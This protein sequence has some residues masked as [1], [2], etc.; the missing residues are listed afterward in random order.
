MPF[1][2][3][4]QPRLQPRSLHLPHSSTSPDTDTAT[5]TQIPYYENQLKHGYNYL[6]PYPIW[7]FKHFLMREFSLC[8]MGRNLE[9]EV[10]AT[11]AY[12]RTCQVNPGYGP[13]LRTG[14]AGTYAGYFR[15]FHLSTYTLHLTPS[16]W[17]RINYRGLI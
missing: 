16:G 1:T 3:Y 17:R 4:S 7:Q 13:Q 9:I 10:E 6:I 2:T 5:N 15:T 8:H 14:R 11:H 12:L